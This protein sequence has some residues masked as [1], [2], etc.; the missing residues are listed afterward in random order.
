MCS[1]CGLESVH[2]PVRKP[3]FEMNRRAPN[4]CENTARLDNKRCVCGVVVVVEHVRFEV[5]WLIQSLSVDVVPHWV[6]VV[7]F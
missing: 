7:R 5:H 3:L 6:V 4:G 2:V 1:C